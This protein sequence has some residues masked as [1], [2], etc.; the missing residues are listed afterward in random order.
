MSKSY[1][2]LR[3]RNEWTPV[4]MYVKLSLFKKTKLSWPK[5]IGE[6]QLDVSV[7]TTTL[8]S[9]LPLIVS[10][11]VNSAFTIWLLISPEIVK[12]TKKPIFQPKT[13][14]GLNLPKIPMKI[15]LP[16]RLSQL[17]AEMCA[18][19]NFRE[20]HQIYAISA[21]F[22]EFYIFSEIRWISSISAPKAITLTWSRGLSPSGGPKKYSSTP[23]V[24]KCQI[25][26]NFT[27]WVK[28][29]ILM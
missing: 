10:V 29:L 24:R 17:R 4:H 15:A 16:G 5:I 8:E 22:S 7:L 12:F 14:F 3:L 27:F 9:S 21:N 28:S 11:T 1:S 23:K 20:F 18:F 2:V 19:S 6:P 26:L 25:S 13:R